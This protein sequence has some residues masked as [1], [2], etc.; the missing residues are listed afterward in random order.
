MKVDLGTSVCLWQD[1]RLNLSTQ[2]QRHYFSAAMS[3]E[4]YRDIRSRM[5]SSTGSLY[6]QLVIRMRSDAA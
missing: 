3:G 6:N 1:L 4:L 2:I 5:P